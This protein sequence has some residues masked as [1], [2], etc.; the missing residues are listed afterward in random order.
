M[1][2]AVFLSVGLAQAAT[3]DGFDLRKH[4]L[5]LLSLGDLGWIQITNFVVSG[6]LLVAFGVGVARPT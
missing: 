5:S 3:R 1:H 6:L 4:P 2:G